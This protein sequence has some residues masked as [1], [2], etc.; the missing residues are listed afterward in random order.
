MLCSAQDYRPGEPG[1][2]Q[3]IWQ[4]TLG[5]DAVVFVT[6]PP[7]LGEDGSH[8]PGAWHGNLSLPRV[9]QW[10]DVLIAVHNLP[11]DDW[12]G[13]THGYFPTGAFDEHTIHDGWAFARKG[14]G[15]LALAAAQGVEFITHG[16]N[17]YR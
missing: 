10:R 15:Y 9:A 2:Q 13:F 11:A 16:N 6:H 5:P 7:C 1:Y 17:A 8:R 12:L 4:A 14:D 3:H